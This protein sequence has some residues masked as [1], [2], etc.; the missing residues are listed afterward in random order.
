M[1]RSILDSSKK[2]GTKWDSYIIHILYN[3]HSRSWSTK[4]KRIP[5]KPRDLMWLL[6]SHWH[7]FLIKTNELPNV[8]KKKW[9]R[10]KMPWAEHNQIIVVNQRPVS[11]SMS[12]VQ[13]QQFFLLNSR[14]TLSQEKKTKRNSLLFY[15]SLYSVFQS[16]ARLAISVVYLNC[17]VFRVRKY[18]TRSKKQMTT[19]FNHFF[20]LFSSKIWTY[21]K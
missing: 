7:L 16:C 11:M 19:G 20:V 17:G 8:K 13:N 12:F 9:R 2:K 14:I 15:P 3:I 18:E 1:F 4:K 6:N 21:N 10:R 5:G